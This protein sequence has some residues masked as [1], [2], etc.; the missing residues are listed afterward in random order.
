[1]TRSLLRARQIATERGA[2]A[3]ISLEVAPGEV[4]ALMGPNGSGKSTLL[5]VLAGDLQPRA[6]T[7]E[8]GGLQLAA[9]D[10]S[11]LAT[12]RA[13]LPQTSHVAFPVT[14]GD[15]VAI[16][17]LPYRYHGRGSEGE[18]VAWA[19]EAV[20]I[21]HLAHR[22]YQRISGG[23]RQRAQFAR[24]L[25]QIWSPVA[26]GPGR[27][28]LLDEPTN[29]LDPAQRLG[30]LQL[31]RRLANQGIAVVVVLHDLSDA[32]RFADQGLLLRG[33]RMVAQGAIANVLTP[34]HIGIAFDVE[35]G[36]LIDQRGHPHV[37]VIG[38]RRAG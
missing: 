5:N 32:L 12:R 16:G 10:P 18:A 7:V 36:I 2:L 14:V 9:W 24:V 31:L 27:L 4:L 21:A 8:I 23:E 22:S 19:L 38:Q 25:A 1:M 6:G 30:I 17:R 20:G 13:V 15:L 3:D 37:T 34:W 11:D 33:G 28:L 29:N 35:A 26:A